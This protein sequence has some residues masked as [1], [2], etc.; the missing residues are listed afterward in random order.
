MLQSSALVCSLQHCF[1]SAICKC[2]CICEPLNRWRWFHTVRLVAGNTQEA[3]MNTCTP[4]A[5][6]HLHRTISAYWLYMWIDVLFSHHCSLKRTWDPTCVNLWPCG[7][8][9]SRSQDLAAACGTWSPPHLHGPGCLLASIYHN[10][11]WQ[12]RIIRCL[13][14]RI[15]VIW[16][17][18][19]RPI[20][21]R[22]S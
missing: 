6:Q 1:M 17:L 21:L 22:T 8:R 2:K 18:D 15:S 11:G 12:V 4:T 14:F 10:G 9:V 16:R 3:S 5:Q 19:F 13:S 7:L 20:E